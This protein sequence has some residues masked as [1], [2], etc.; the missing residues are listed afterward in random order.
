MLD[1]IPMR[2]QMLMIGV[3]RYGIDTDGNTSDDVTE[4]P[5]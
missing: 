2:F 3:M 5:T 1:Q 4:S